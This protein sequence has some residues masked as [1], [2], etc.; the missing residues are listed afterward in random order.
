MGYQVSRTYCQI[1]F[2]LERS[3]TNKISCA[4]SENSGQSGHLGPESSLS[5][6]KRFGSSATHKAYSENSDP[7]G[8]MS[9]L[10]WFFAG[11]TGHCVGFVML[12]FI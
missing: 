4:P 10:I 1:S 11:C 3:K 2:E 5:A 8:Q 6:Y 7:N 12:C 9:K